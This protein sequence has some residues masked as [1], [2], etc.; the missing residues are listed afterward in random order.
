M[1]RQ[2]DGQGIV[3]SATLDGVTYLNKVCL[4]GVHLAYTYPRQRVS[5]ASVGLRRMFGSLLGTRWV[6]SV[7]LRL[8]NGVRGKR[9][10]TNSTVPL[11]RT[12]TEA[13]TCACVLTFYTL[14]ADMFVAT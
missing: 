8:S 6:V 2:G 11:S 5:L 1:E 13:T 10:G 9:K 7:A 12:Q 4:S 14:I 3:N